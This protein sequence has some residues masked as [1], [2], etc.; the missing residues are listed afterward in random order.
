MS[1]RTSVDAVDAHLC[2]S[3]LCVSLTVCVHCR[4]IVQ[5]EKRNCLRRVQVSVAVGGVRHRR[6]RRHRRGGGQGKWRRERKEKGK[7]A[8]VSHGETINNDQH[9]AS[10]QQRQIKHE[11][12]ISFVKRSC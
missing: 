10:Q 9:Q 1:E 7:G 3:A 2:L 6:R 8:R 5:M 12:D 11:M 4:I